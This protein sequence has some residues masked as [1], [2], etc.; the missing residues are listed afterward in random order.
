MATTEAHI[1]AQREAV[2]AVLADGDCYD[3][4]V[5]GAKEIRRSDRQWP[6]EGTKL[7]HTVGAGPAELKDETRVIESDPP[8][9][10]VLS[11]KAR[12]VGV[13]RVEMQLEP[14]GAG[15]RVVMIETVTDG[16]ARWVPRPVLD[17]LID[18]RNRVALDRLRDLVAERA[19]KGLPE[20]AVAV[21]MP[22]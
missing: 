5:V 12:P 2:F 13:A 18:R 6:R 10:L 3:E 22:E 16:P 8:R 21:E 4:W 1:D 11:A 19:G 7:D 17:F 15:T 9:R 14:E 20:E